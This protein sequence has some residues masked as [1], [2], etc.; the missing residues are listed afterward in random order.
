MLAVIGFLRMPGPLI[1]LDVSETP[2]LEAVL[3]PP[4]RPA[5]PP[6]AVPHPTPKP[7]PA[8]PQPVPKAVET[9]PEPPAPPVA[10]SEGGTTETV[11]GPGGNGAGAAAAPSPA[12]APAGPAG[13]PAQEGEK[14]VPPPSATMHYASFVN[15]VQNPDGLI[16]WEQDGKHY[17]LAVETRVLWFRFAFQSSGVM[18]ET[19]LVPE[20][21]EE[22]RRGKSEAARFDQSAGT[23]AFARGTQA[24]L[25]PGAQD[26]F[27]VFLQLVGRVRGNPQRYAAPGV[28]EAFQVADT[29]DMQPMQVQYVGEEEIDTGRGMVR[30]KH[31]VRLQRH[32]GDKR[33]VEIW[34]AQ[35]LGW[36]PVRLRQ[37]EPDGTQI[38]LV[39]RS[40]EGQ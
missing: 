6:P 36:M 24:Q 7:R 27:S 21:Y 15:G 5:R 13:P 1:P 16:R 38:D 23:V 10:T 2:A 11:T 33:R 35:S 29:R 26:R 31:F 32:A 18:T 28:T 8:A 22:N 30:A 12:P 4:P 19:G 37:T 25:S 17:R 34:L 9:P 14:Y 20:R 3:L 39:Y 40:T